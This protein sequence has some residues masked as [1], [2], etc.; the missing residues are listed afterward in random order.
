LKSTAPGPPFSVKARVEIEAIVIP[1]LD[2]GF[3]VVVPALPGCFAE[4]DTVEEIQA[5]IIE[6]AESWLETVHARNAEQ[7]MKDAI[8]GSL[9]LVS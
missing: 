2:G 3:S 1:E 8:E 9:S 5:N 7:A 4:G 6:A